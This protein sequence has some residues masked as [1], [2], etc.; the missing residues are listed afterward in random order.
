MTEILLTGTLKLNSIKP[1]L[2][3][4]T[5]PFPFY[6]LFSVNFLLVFNFYE[7]SL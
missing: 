3:N 1:I 7:D 4:W 5:S 6:G 2:I